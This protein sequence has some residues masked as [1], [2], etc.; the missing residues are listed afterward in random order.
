MNLRVQARHLALTCVWVVVLISAGA[1]I[2]WWLDISA[3]KKLG[4]NFPTMRPNTAVGLVWGATG[5]L[6]L[7][8][9]AVSSGRRLA[10]RIVAGVMSAVCILSVTAYLTG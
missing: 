9:P 1:L 2:G 5:L 7:W 4:H 8:N 6:L 10:A 3:L